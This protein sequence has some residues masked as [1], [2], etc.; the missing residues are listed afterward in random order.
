M[1]ENRDAKEGPLGPIVEKML[2]I[3]HEHP[4]FTP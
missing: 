3:N 4:C 2:R 1:K